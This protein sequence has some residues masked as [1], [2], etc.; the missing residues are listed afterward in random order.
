MNSRT[1]VFV[2]GTGVALFIC[3]KLHQR[4][5]N[6]GIYEV[7]PIYKAIHYEDGV[8][9]VI[10]NEWGE[11]KNQL[12]MDKVLPTHLV[13]IYYEDGGDNDTNNGRVIGQ[14]SI[15]GRL[16]DPNYT[17]KTSKWKGKSDPVLYITS[18][19]IEPKFRGNGWGKTLMACVYSYSLQN[20]FNEQ[21]VKN[22]EGQ[23]GSRNLVSFYSKL[24]GTVLSSDLKLQQEIGMDLPHKK[25]NVDLN[26]DE[27]TVK[28]N[29]LLAKQSSNFNLKL[30]F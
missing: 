2:C 7:I 28:T 8:K 9:E 16:G 27:L 21:G 4:L 15:G 22:I 20:K 18:L 26:N 25:M 13:L 23:T 30:S 17:G 6:T 29:Q 5:M 11:N 3:R 14:V 19:V 10:A 24:G 1:A 12:E